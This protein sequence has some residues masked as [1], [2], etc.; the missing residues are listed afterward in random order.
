LFLVGNFPL[1]ETWRVIQ[2]YQQSQMDQS[3]SVERKKIIHQPVLE[4]RSIQMEVACPKLAIGVRGNQ[5][6]AE[7]SIY[8][9]RL[10]LSLLFA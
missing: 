8:R 3:S 6:L 4:K 9:Y 2:D 1:A 7:E 5:K 10:S